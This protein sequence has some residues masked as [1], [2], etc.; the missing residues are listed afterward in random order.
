MRRPALLLVCLLALALPAT[1]LALRA[2]PGDG[3]LV[4]R[5]AS[6]PQKSPVVAL[7]ITGA[8]IGH[9][10]GL[11]HIVIDPGT[12]NANTPEVSGYDWR[13][14]SQ[15]SDTAQVW[16]GTDFKFR[17]IGGHWTI[18]IYG[19]DVD[20]FAIGKGTVTLT[21]LADDPKGDGTY[22]TNGQDF[23]SLPGTPVQRPIGLTTVG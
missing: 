10:T 23:R 9:I 7:N 20:V 18:L 16:G 1:A 11:G 2:A 17:A 15:T 13:N 21:G 22:S 3:T 14:D 12:S 19:S 4:V 5:D 8:V 6:G